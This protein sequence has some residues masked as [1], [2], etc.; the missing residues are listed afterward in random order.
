MQLFDDK[1]INFQSAT[2][3]RAKN[4]GFPTRVTRLK[5]APTMADPVCIKDSERHLN[6]RPPKG[7]LQ[8]PC[9]FTRQLFWA[10]EG[11]KWLY[12]TYTNPIMDLFTKNNRNLEVPY[13]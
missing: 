2:C 7:G 13:G 6:P 1:L 3:Q 8:P 12:V 10:T 5:V 9:D 11:C 4:Y